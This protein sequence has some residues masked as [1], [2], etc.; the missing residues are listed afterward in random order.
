VLLRAPHGESP[1]SRPFYGTALGGISAL[2]FCF[3]LG[4]IGRFGSR[5][6]AA[7]V[8]LG[9]F[10]TMALVPFLKYPPT[11]LRSVTRPRSISAPLFSPMTALSVLLAIGAVLFGRA[12]A[13]R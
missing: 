1:L 8:S 2:A 6:T 11:R 10:I 12:L 13:S 4:R 7:L 5:A 3:A 9:G